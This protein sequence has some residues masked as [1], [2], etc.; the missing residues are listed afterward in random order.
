MSNGF[1]YDRG[2]GP[3]IAGTRITVFNLIP[4]FLEADTTEAT[5]CKIYNLSPGQV[6]AARAYV[7]NHFDDVMAVHRK[8]EARNAA[9]NPPEVVEQMRRTH[10]AFE[11]YRRQFSERKRAEALAKGRIGR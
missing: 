9:G 4:Y 2:C 7:L 6:A 3:Q 10:V 8:I 1:I 11:T 5:I